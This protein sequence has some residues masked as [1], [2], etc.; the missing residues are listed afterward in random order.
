MQEHGKRFLSKKEVIEAGYP[1]TL[2]HLNQLVF[3][4]AIPHVKVGKNIRFESDQ[5]DA[6]LTARRVP[7]QAHAA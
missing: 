5:L 6:W 1:F 3:K 2:S 7:V 4:R